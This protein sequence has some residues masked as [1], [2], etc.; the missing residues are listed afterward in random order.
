MFMPNIGVAL[1]TITCGLDS[2]FDLNDLL[3][4]FVDDH[5]T[6]KLAISNFCP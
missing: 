4:S 6:I 5:W 3:S 1:L 2:A